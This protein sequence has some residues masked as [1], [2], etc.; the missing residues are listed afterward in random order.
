MKKALSLLIVLFS[1]TFFCGCG[2]MTGAVIGGIAGGPRGAAIGA[3]AGAALIDAPAI[4]AEQRRQQY[5]APVQNCYNDQWGRTFCQQQN[6]QT[7]YYNNPPI[8]PTYP[9]R[10][11]YND[12]IQPG[13]I[14]FFGS[15]GRHHRHQIQRQENNKTP[16][17]Q[18]KR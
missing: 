2:T 5:Y 6:I 16:K 12:P 17:Y 15:D 8:Y 18:R 14:F 13:V 1:L 10:Y 11:W 3:L 9:W 4:A 7:V